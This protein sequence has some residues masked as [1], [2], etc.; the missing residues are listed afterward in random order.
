MWNLTKE[1][2][3]KTKLTGKEIRLVVTRGRGVVGG[4]TVRR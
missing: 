3:R 2:N 1:K 4:A